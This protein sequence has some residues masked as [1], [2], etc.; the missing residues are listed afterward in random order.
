[1]AGASPSFTDTH[2]VKALLSLEA[3]PLGRKRLTETLG[4]GEGSV[5]TI[6][7]RLDKQGLISSSLSGHSLTE[8][9]RREAD[10]LLERFTKPAAFDSGGLLA[11]VQ[12]AVVVKRPF[13]RV[14]AVAL[15]DAA[16][17]AGAEGAVTILYD[18]GYRF[19]GGGL[20]ASGYPEFLVNLSSLPLKPGYAA[21]IGFASNMHAA[22]D[23]ALSAAMMLSGLN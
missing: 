2:M 6:I 1:M 7:K 19:L 16:L 4:V 15:R 3:G 10:R 18:G 5:R 9:G 17:R 21:V 13:P 11:G 14:S 12:S 22:E 20:E 8:A 23:G